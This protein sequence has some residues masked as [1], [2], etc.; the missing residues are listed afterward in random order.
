MIARRTRQ[1][2]PMS[3]LFNTI[4]SLTSAKLCVLTAGE[5]TELRIVEPLTMQPCDTIEPTAEGGLRVGA[6]VRNADLAADPRVR[7]DWPLLSRAI[8]AGASGY[9]VK[10]V[11]FENFLQA[12]RA[13]EDFWLTFVRFPPRR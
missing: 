11:G 3:T 10:P 9:V 8:L 12:I 4:E 7:R 5:S 13:F 1:L 2:R 6:L